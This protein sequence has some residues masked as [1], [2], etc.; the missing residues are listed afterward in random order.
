MR[1]SI[2]SLIV[3]VVFAGAAL[4]MLFSNRPQAEQAT[5]AVPVIATTKIMVATRD[6]AYG[7]KIVPDF[8]K[9]VDWPTESVPKEAILTPADLLEGPEAPRIALRP[10]SAGEPYLRSKVS[11]F[12][13]RP[14][15]SRKLGEGMRAFTV[16]IN[17]VSGVGGFILPG[18]RVDV[19]LTRQLDGRSGKDSLATDVLLQNV[20]VLGID[21]LSSENANEPVLG[22]SA[23]F[24]VTPE[25]AQKLALATQVGSLSLSLRN[26]TALKEEKIG[27]IG[28]RDLGVGKVAP[29]APRAAPAAPRDNSIYVQ[30][31]KGTEVEQEKVSR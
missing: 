28:A 31:R 27:Q 6:I 10:M 3:G 15:L 22:K 12:G 29:S 23:T 11:G 30:V 25:Q 14:I 24:E 16:R 2:Y 7:G 18:D 1:R 21:Q 17:D 8:V 20:T 19:L 13:E 9:A 26:Y 4:W 5:A